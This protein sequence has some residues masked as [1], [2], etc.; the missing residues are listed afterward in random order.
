MIRYLH[1][2]GSV[3]QRITLPI[4]IPSGKSA[5]L[6]RLY[7][8]KNIFTGQDATYKLSLDA[9]VLVVRAWQYS[10]KLAHLSP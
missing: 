2:M 3:I 10:C 9:L 4:I 1:I 7:C 5:L 6:T 8:H